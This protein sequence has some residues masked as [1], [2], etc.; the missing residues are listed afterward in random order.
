MNQQRPRRRWGRLLVFF[1]FTFATAFLCLSVGLGSLT[2]A[3]LTH[4]PCT[5][6]TDTPDDFADD[7]DW[8]FVDI[9]TVSGE[10]FRAIIVRGSN[11]AA[12]IY[13]PA[14][15]GSYGSRLDEALPMADA[16]YS[17]LTYDSRRCAGMGPISLGYQEVAEVG[18]VLDYLNT[19]EVIDP[20]RIGIDGFSSGGATAIMAAAQYPQI[21]A[22]VASGGYADMNDIVDAPESP[23]PFYLD[24]YRL[25]MRG[26]YRLII[27]SSM[28]TLS[29]LSHISDI[30]PRP[31]L[32]IYGT[33]EPSLNGAR[34][35]QAA[36][37]DNARLWVVEDTGHGG[38]IGALGDR[39]FVEVR[40]FFDKHLLDN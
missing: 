1:L 2:V 26:T 19:H 13:P 22:V 28:Q 7:Y 10:H 9:P 32:L 14:L 18:A 34:Q 35:Q 25:G 5:S 30:A 16:G 31:I 6:N 38:Y 33:E 8:N 20:D 4:V 36:A 17:T 3:G 27:G 15:G 40:A 29:P 21:R 12:I 37:G 23:V 11:R 24:L 39:Y